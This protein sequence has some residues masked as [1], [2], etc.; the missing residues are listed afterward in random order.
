LTVRVNFAV[1]HHPLRPACLERITG[2]HQLTRAVQVVR[3]PRP[4]DAPSPWRTYKLA[5]QS[6]PAWATHQLIVQDDALVCPGFRDAAVRCVTSKPDDLV[7]FFCSPYP[8]LCAINVVEAAQRCEHWAELFN[9]DWCPVVALAWPRW[10]IDQLL[11]WAPVDTLGRSDDTVVG[12]WLNETGHHALC[13][14]PNLVQHPDDVASV[15][16]SD[17]LARHSICWI[18]DYDASLIDW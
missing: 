9:G 7:S 1:Q 12:R 2:P 13:T 4:G 5:L 16:G 14:V 3:D 18:G 11:A 6:I 10:M 15:M 17:G 8:Q